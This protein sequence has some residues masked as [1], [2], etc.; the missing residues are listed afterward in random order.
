MEGFRSHVCIG[1][2]TPCWMEWPCP[3][4]G[5]L[6]IQAKKLGPCVLCTTQIQQ[7]TGAAA[8]STRLLWSDILR[9]PGP[10]QVNHTLCCPLS[11]PFPRGGGC[12]RGFSGVTLGFAEHLCA[13]RRAAR[14]HTLPCCPQ[15]LTASCPGPC[16]RSYSQMDKM[17]RDAFLQPGK[18]EEA[19]DFAHLW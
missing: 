11:A 15:T 5:D 18:C 4:I 13:W 16:K 9:P 3:N 6:T 1:V 10:N 7:D 8:S 17:G 19:S 2:T 14:V 12:A